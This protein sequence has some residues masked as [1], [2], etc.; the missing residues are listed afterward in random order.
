MSV[1]TSTHTLRLGTRGSMLAR[2]QSQMMADAIE[3]RHPGLKVELIICK[4]T[5]DKIQDRP[6]HEAGG[7]GLFTKE[8]EE[9]LLAKTV[10]FAVHSFKDVPV[11]MPLVYQSELIIAAVP[12]REDPRDVLACAKSRSIRDL[13]QGAK[14]GTGS[15]RRRCQILA[16]RSDLNVELIRGNIDTRVRKLRE[17][18]YDAVILALAGLK[19]S[20][21]FDGTD[22]NPVPVEDMLPAAAQGALAI[23]C[24][25][26]DG[27]TREL[28]SVLNDP[29]AHECVS[30]ERS[31]VQALNGDC[32]S[33]IAA[34]ATIH[35]KTIRLQAAVGA[36][37]GELPVIR[38]QAEGNP[39][40]AKRVLDTVMKSLESQRVRELLA[41]NA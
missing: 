22:M 37:G 33:P 16:L 30:L 19:R 25:R 21:M 9:A 2:V 18:Q 7:K 32:H 40:D 14:V 17:G 13:P 15:L 8:L 31:L 29:I 27:R 11:T 5:G 28:L 3:K 12:P 10:D 20:G 39:G 4:T 36:R 1:A 34:L 38:A 26:D 41:G 35:G 6:L 23:Q 24:R